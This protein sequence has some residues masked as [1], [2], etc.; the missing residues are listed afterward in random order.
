M[1]MFNRFVNVLPAS[2]FGTI[3]MRVIQWRFA[4]SLLPL[5][6]IQAMKKDI[7]KRKEKRSANA[8]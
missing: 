3:F 1:N 2:D 4:A 8:Q 7:W 5:R 6:A